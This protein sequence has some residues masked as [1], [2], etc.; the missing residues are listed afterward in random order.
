M[1][2]RVGQQLGNYRII[3]LIGR[4]GFAD[5]YLGEHIY[6]RTQVAMKVLRTTVTNQEDLDGFLMEAQTVARLVHPAIIRITDFGVDGDIPFLVMD[7]APNGTLR[8]R[9]PKGTQVPLSTV[10][11][12]VKQ[13]VAALQHAHDEQLI[14]RD[15]KAENMLLG[16]RDH[17]LL[18]DFG[19]ALIAQSS[20]HQGTQEMAGTIPYMAP[21]QIQGK[22][23]PASDQYS[24]AVVVY[25]WLSGDRPFHGSFTE[26]ATQ[27]VLAAPPALREKMP[28]PSPAVEAV[29]LTALAKDPHQRFKSVTAFANALEQASLLE[30]STPLASRL[31]STSL[32]LPGE[33]PV[34]GMALQ[35]QIAEASPP[36]PAHSER[37]ALSS[38]SLEI[39][40]PALVSPAELLPPETDPARLPLEPLTTVSSPDSAEMESAAVVPGEKPQASRSRA[41]QAAAWL[42]RGL[43]KP[44]L[45]AGALGI[46]FFGGFNYSIDS[47]Y[48][49]S[50]PLVTAT[51]SPFGQSIDAGIALAGVALI[52][53]LFLAVISGPLVGLITV[54]AGLYLGDLLAGYSAVYDYYAASW[55]WF[56]G[57]ILIGLI[58]GLAFFA[59]RGR[60]YT[61]RSIAVGVAMSTMGVLVGTAFTTYGDVWVSGKTV[62]DAGATFT[63]L[64]LPA[65]VALALLPILLVAY[66]AI[67]RHR[68]SR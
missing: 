61:A 54:T 20:R 53:P 44:Q 45:V 47:L 60:Y 10:V 32:T 17:V 65:I 5:V 39:P 34:G 24:L 16:R 55:T 4:G 68:A 41:G 50:S 8:Q 3:G 30:Q 19:I 37:I 46:L 63:L 6:L 23:R 57:H 18:S 36:S 15:V 58:A 28:A 67:T 21:E 43:G 51:L 56:A 7:Y 31:S 48:R 25:E 38:P 66:G 40:S 33:P 12:Y 42:R 11:L 22:P 29:I 35:A 2:Y 13:V 1:A 14:H 52:V 26:I 59:T 62:A 64:I 9:H 49:V 27:H